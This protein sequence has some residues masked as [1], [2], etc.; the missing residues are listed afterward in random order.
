[1]KII[2]LLLIFFFINSTNASEVVG[3]VKAKGLFV[4]DT[5]KVIAF[6]D[7]TIEGVRC[8]TTYYNRRLSL[9]DSSSS[10]IACRK[11]GNISGEIKNMS[12]VFKS[13]KGFFKKTVVDRL[14][15][16]KGNTLIY[17]SYSKD[18]SDKNA[19]H[20]ISVVPLKEGL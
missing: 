13:M 15:D 14:Y 1:M 9:L 20:S 12:N 3:E 17:L 11:V 18:S 6:N 4:K 2:S 10:S 16:K 19:S 8:W 5:I 7:P